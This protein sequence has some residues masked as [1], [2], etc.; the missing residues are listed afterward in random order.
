MDPRI[1]ARKSNSYFGKRLART[2]REHLSWLAPGGGF[3]EQFVQRVL[4]RVKALGISDLR[5]RRNR[6]GSRKRAALT[7]RSDPG[8]A[9]TCDLRPAGSGAD[10]PKAGVRK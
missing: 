9:I 6:S 7:L 5:A 2:I 4:E 8:L 10:L 3:C 1:D